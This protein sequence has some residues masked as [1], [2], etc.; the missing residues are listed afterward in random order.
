LLA[1][2]LIGL[3]APA[4]APA[5]YGILPELLPADELVL[6][7]A[8][9]E[10][11]TV[12]ATL[13]GVALGSMLLGASWPLAWFATPAHSATA[14]TLLLFACALVASLAIPRGRASAPGALGQPGRLVRRFAASCA[15]L[16]S[17]PAAGRSLAATCV[18]WA[19]AAALQFII[20]RWGTEVLGLSLGRA[21]LLQ[22]ALAV[23]VIA[24]AGCAARLVPLGRA[25]SVLPLGLPAGALVVALLWVS[26]PLI[27]ALMVTALGWLA[28]LLLVPMN[29]LLQTR[30]NGLMHAGQSVAVQSFSENGAAF[31]VL[32]VYGLLS[33]ADVSLA[34][35]MAMA[36]VAV[37]GATVAGLLRP[38]AA[39]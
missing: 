1:F 9:M 24:G 32:L 22:A 12:A 39:L 18:F 27:A 14:G 31:A 4:H 3:G 16:W 7:N 15:T 34:A 19:V 28:G 13:G 17:D 38:A 36:G 33:K 29:A 35:T 37:M 6:A 20:L 23:G 10:M 21:A 5:R 11:A 25:L 30:G 26:T 8:W 2:G